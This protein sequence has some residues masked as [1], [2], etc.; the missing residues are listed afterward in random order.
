MHFLIWLTTSLFFAPLLLS[1]TK[2]EGAVIETGQKL[3]FACAVSLIEFYGVMSTGDPHYS[4]S[5]YFANVR[6]IYAYPIVFA[7]SIVLAPL[8]CRIPFREG[9]VFALLFVAAKFGAYT[10]IGLIF[11]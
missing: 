8:I 10:L 4:G 2:P 3:I 5:S 9:A 6:Q 7:A 11:T 1:L